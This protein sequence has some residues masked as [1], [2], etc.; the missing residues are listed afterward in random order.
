ML[1]SKNQLKSGGKKGKN[2]NDPYNIITQLDIDI[3]L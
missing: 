1:D 2:D 3:D